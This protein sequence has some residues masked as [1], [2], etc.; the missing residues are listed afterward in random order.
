MDNRQ[1]NTILHHL[2]HLTGGNSTL[3][4]GQLLGRFVSS[5]D[6]AAFELLIRRHG[7]LVWGIC[8]RILG[9]AHD[10]EDAFQAVFLILV[11][12]ASSLN[13]TR[14]LAAWLHG[15]AC[16]VAVRARDAS[17][18]RQQ[19]ERKSVRTEAV[20]ENT[21]ETHDLRSVLDEELDRLP[22]NFR[23]PLVLCYLEG[24]T[25]EEAA[26][27][28]GWP[29][30]TLKCRVKRGRELL[31]TRLARRG[32]APHASLPVV[33]P[34]LVV[35]SPVVLVTLQAAVQFTAG[36]LVAGPSS[37]Q[38]I[39]LAEGVLKAMTMS[40]LKLAAALLTLATFLTAGA[41]GLVLQ[42]RSETPARTA[43][44][45]QAPP[46][47]G[48]DAKTPSGGEEA[49]PPAKEVKP[50]VAVSDKL[51]ALWTDLAS[52][53]RAKAWRAALTLA[54]APKDALTLFKARLKP[55]TVDEDYLAKRI[56]QLDSDEFEVRERASEELKEAGEVAVPLLKKALENTSS[57]EV[58]RRIEELL[59]PVRLAMASSRSA[60]AV[61]VL[62][63]IGNEDARKLLEALA[64]GRTAAA[65][66]QAAKA[67]LGRMGGK[68]AP[69]QAHWDAVGGADETAA[70]RAALAIVGA[71]KESLP[72]LKANLKKGLPGEGAEVDEK[73]IAK[74]MADLDSE[75]DQTREK[76]IGDLK[77]QGA[78]ALPLI[79]KARAERQSQELSRRLD[80]ILNEIKWAPPPGIDVVA[81]RLSIVL[82]HL[83]TPEAREVLE[84]V[85]KVQAE[86]VRSAVSPDGRFV[87]AIDKVR[88]TLQDAAT[89]KIIWITQIGNGTP[90]CVAFSPDGKV[91][92]AG[93]D[94]GG[95]CLIDVPTGKQLRLFRSKVGVVRITFSPDGKVLQSFHVAEM[96]F[97]WDMATGQ[98]L[99]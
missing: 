10:A 4:D 74:L 68:P 72:F 6:A 99:P 17:F 36:S 13:L 76:A 87:V 61:L 85:R 83:D 8:R 94:L 25:Q 46:G 2:H 67:A 60:R 75:N 77:A 19:R 27:Q 32:L 66:T 51:E 56:R 41:G 50:P 11:R 18:R 1:L 24:L 88:L 34:P 37:T 43:S 7:P 95:I 29:L 40:K 53:D 3:T 15:V 91:V 26:R 31:R 14:T 59:E 79:R 47:S 9:N 86:N 33:P 38:A 28:L 93:T 57:A 49:K 39:A 55:V 23:T 64:R 62:E 20:H 71:P 98:Q 80:L 84:L 52:D 90:L 97:R 21:A 54:T 81:E 16:R 45:P 42:A 30:G 12:R 44:S 69:W 22:D 89:G 5:R 48:Q 63:T 65:L 92:A 96:M 35:P 82:P 58:R 70:L 73:L 78:A